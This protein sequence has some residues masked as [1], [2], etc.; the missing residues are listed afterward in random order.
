VGVGLRGLLLPQLNSHSSRF[1]QTSQAPI[2]PP[3]PVARPSRSQQRPLI[4]S[5][6]APSS[7]LGL[8]RVPLPRPGRPCTAAYRDIAF[9]RLA[10]SRYSCL[11][12]G[13]RAWVA[14]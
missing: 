12:W 4:F 13:D 9:S 11:F 6:V 2:F 8:R 3:V 10:S 5:S 14:S 7:A 1:L